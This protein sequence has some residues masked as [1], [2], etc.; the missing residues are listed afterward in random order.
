MATVLIVDDLEANREFLSALL[1]FRGH[2]LIEAADG[3]E[4]LELARAEHPD[5][6]IS[7]ILMP[8]MDGYQF[9]QQLRGDPSI[10]ET[11]VIF[12]TGQFLGREA[13]ALARK[14]GVAFVISKPCEP[15]EVLRIVDTALGVREMPAPPSD[16]TEFDREHLSMI[17][18]K[19]MAKV[20]ELSAVNQKMAALIEVGQ[21]LASEHHPLLLLED[22]CRA[23]RTIIGASCAAVGVLSEDEQTLCHFYACGLNDKSVERTGY[24]QPDDRVPARLLIDNA[25]IRMHNLEGDPALV[26]LPPEFPMIHSFLGVPIMFNARVY[27]WLSLANKLGSDEFGE[28]DEKLAC[29]LAAQMAVAYEN[30]LLYDE[31]G[32]YNDELELELDQRK[33]IADERA[34]ILE[35]EKQA[36]KG[37]EEFSRAKDLFLNTISRELREPLNAILGWARLLRSKEF[38]RATLLYATDTIE[39]NINIQVQLIDDLLDTSRIEKGKL[40]LNL[41]PLD[42]GP[43]LHAAVDVA[44]PAAVAKGIRLILTVDSGATRVT[45]DPSGLRQIVSN[46][47]A[48]AIKSTPGGGCITV[49]LQRSDGKAEIAVRDTGQGINPDLL[50]HVFA[51]NFQSDNPA[52][53]AH[54]GLGIGL[55]AVLQRIEMHGGSIQAESPGEGQGTV[56]TIKL[57]LRHV[58][59]T[60]DSVPSPQVVKTKARRAGS[61]KITVQSSTRHRAAGK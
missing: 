31:V 32:N 56:F 10:G 41:Q 58:R 23:A 34:K 3:L 4:G 60:E 17:S 25:S 24:P 13:T 22:Y 52:P 6:I 39:R 14:C 29:T 20:D 35:K 15:E 18:D 38:D 47:L 9:V 33:H 50:P 48:N 55:S 28:E 37:A 53:A 42:L 16:F 43:I 26:G 57:P 49:R 21:H 44:Q 46:L 51:P 7:D 30:A 12:S 27:G 59:A 2:R 5:L 8:A 61:R 45:G 19:L 54:S 40:Q 1:S 11:T 36:R